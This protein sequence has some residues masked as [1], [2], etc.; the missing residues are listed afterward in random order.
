MCN[1]S[2]DTLGE[3]DL[4]LELCITRYVW[5]EFFFLRVN[6]GVLCIKDQ[7]YSDDNYWNTVRY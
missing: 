3:F 4:M 7:N 2:D 6:M 5:S 1:V